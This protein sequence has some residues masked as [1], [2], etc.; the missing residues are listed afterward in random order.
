MLQ[1]LQENIRTIFAMTFMA[2]WWMG[3]GF[4]SIKGDVKT[5]DRKRVAKGM[6]AMTDDEKQLVKQTFRSSVMQNF[7][8]VCD[9]R[10]RFHCVSPFLLTYAHTNQNEKQI[11]HDIK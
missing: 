4:L 7:L 8:Q 6:A 5:L 2:V 9:C 11:S 10:H 3:N 1:F